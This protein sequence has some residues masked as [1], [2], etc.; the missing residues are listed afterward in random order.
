MIYYELRRILRNPKWKYSLFIV[1]GSLFYCITILDESSD[2]MRALMRMQGIETLQSICLFPVILLC[3]LLYHIAQEEEHSQTW[4]T[5]LTYPVPQGKR[6][7]SKLLVLLFLQLPILAFVGIFYYFVSGHVDLSVLKFSWS[8][9]ILYL[10]SFMYYTFNVSDGY[11]SQMGSVKIVNVLRTTTPM[12]LFFCITNMKDWMYAYDLLWW[13]ITTVCVLALLVLIIFIKPM[14]HRKL[15]REMILY[16]LFGFASSWQR[17]KMRNDLHN[18]QDKAL[19]FLFH[20]IPTK[21][22]GYWRM[23]A[24]VEVGLKTN[25]FYLLI[26]ILC[27]ILWKQ[28]SW[29]LFMFIMLL[30]FA[31]VLYGCIRERNRIRRMKI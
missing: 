29:I 30:S 31:Y 28:T 10:T 14:M 12:F 16:K 5:L 18:V 26:G 13:L 25:G 8:M 1:L 19:Q 7:R 6:V 23:C 4:K 21:S 27:F 9:Q 3:V 2:S 20:L 17:E 22:E 11:I 24:F 15:Y